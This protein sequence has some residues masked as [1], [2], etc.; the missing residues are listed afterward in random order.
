MPDIGQIAWSWATERENR[1]MVFLLLFAILGGL[2][3]MGTSAY[4]AW[5]AD[6]PWVGRGLG[7]GRRRRFWA[8]DVIDRLLGRG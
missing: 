8:G 7:R 1:F 5:K 3:V 2:I 4:D 6:L